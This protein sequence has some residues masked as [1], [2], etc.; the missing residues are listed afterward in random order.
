MSKGHQNPRRPPHR[1]DRRE[2]SFMQKLSL[3]EAAPPWSIITAAVTAAVILINLI[4]V[5]PAMS[6]LL[7]GSVQPSPFLL[8][9]GW[10]FGLALTAAY[11]LVNRRSSP[12]SWQALRLKPGFLPS[13]IALLVGVAIALGVGLMVSL[14]SGRFLP[15]AEIY[16]F[17][18]Q[19]LAGTLAAALLL[20]VMQP[21][22]EGL[23]FQ[24]VILPSLRST[25]G[26][27]GGV[28]ITSGLSALLHYAVFFSP[29]QAEYG[30]AFWH[31]LVYPLL[32]GLG[33]CLLKV[34][35]DSSRAVII[36]RVGAGL[37]SW[38]TALALVGG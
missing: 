37:V 1:A 10:T 29:W 7:L 38:L 14:A 17:Q 30:G 8:M 6:S 19:G 20:T 15:I 2:M 11:A 16:G 35:A 18:T 21:I 33:F 32:T 25:I 23:V 9:L 13:Q 12:Q 31:G 34:Y 26:H 5:G 3:P 28:F 36:G 24:A 27:W 22:A 4:W